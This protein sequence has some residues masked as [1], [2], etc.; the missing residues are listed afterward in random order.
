MH[1]PERTGNEPGKSQI[2]ASQETIAIKPR[3]FAITD[4]EFSAAGA[5]NT[6]VAGFIA[7]PTRLFFFI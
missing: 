1:A 5:S 4:S 2:K 7:L 3:F 6:G